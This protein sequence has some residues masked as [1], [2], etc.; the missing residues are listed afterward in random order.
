MRP[1][2]FFIGLVSTGA[3]DCFTFYVEDAVPAGDVR[4]MILAVMSCMTALCLW[5][6][7]ESAEDES[8]LAGFLRFLFSGWTWPALIVVLALLLLLLSLSERNGFES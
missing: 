7:D 1:I 3:V 5:S 8:P 4:W 6:Q 2:G